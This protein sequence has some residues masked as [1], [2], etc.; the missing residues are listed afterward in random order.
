MG[1]CFKGALWEEVAVHER[2]SADV[3]VAGG[4]TVYHAD[5]DPLM[6]FGGH[7]TNILAFRYE[8]YFSLKP[9]I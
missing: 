7:T 1:S 4:S 3:M 8:Y 9:V 5:P 2:N 6:I